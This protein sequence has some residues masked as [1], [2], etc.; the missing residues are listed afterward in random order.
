MA[1]L[2]SGCDQNPRAD[3]RGVLDPAP[4]V[5]VRGGRGRTGSAAWMLRTDRLH[6]CPAGSPTLPRGLG[7]PRGSTAERM[8]F[9]EDRGGAVAT[10][11]GCAVR[12]RSAPSAMASGWRLSRQPRRMRIGNHCSRADTPAP[13]ADCQDH[14]DGRRPGCHSPRNP[15]FTRPYREVTAVTAKGARSSEATLPRCLNRVET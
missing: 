15:Y 11:R 8:K 5:Y 3:A 2:V 9:I 4:S 13:T 14:Y 7:R 12:K 10:Q 1:F 6:S